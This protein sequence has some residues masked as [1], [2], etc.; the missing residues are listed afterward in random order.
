MEGLIFK[1]KRKRSKIK[2]LCV[3]NDSKIDKSVI[4]RFENLKVTLS[5][6]QINSLFSAINEGKEVDF[7]QKIALIKYVENIY[8]NFMQGV[9]FEYTFQEY[10][11]SEW[12]YIQTNEYFAYLIG[13]LI[14][15]YDN[16]YAYE[17]SSVQ[18]IIQ[19]LTEHEAYI[20]ISLQSIFFCMAG[21]Y[22]VKQAK[23]SQALNLF[24]KSN[25]TASNDLQKAFAMYHL[26]KHR[27]YSCDLLDAID[28]FIPAKKIYDYYFY[29]KS[30]LLVQI[31]IG[32]VYLKMGLYTK[33]EEIFL[34]CLNLNKQYIIESDIINTVCSLLF[35]SYLNDKNYNKIIESSKDMLERNINVVLCY[36][37]LAISYY[38][39]NDNENANKYILLAWKNKDYDEINFINKEMISAYRLV[40]NHKT[41]EKYEKKFLNIYQKALD[42]KDLHLQIYILETLINFAKKEDRTSKLIEYYSLLH[43]KYKERH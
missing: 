8:L 22:C 18:E 42:K 39:L 43:D 25:S 17:I 11:N 37:C 9:Q 4:S 41:F 40:I 36:V 16:D 35:Y 34:N 7:A 6:E 26:G 14:Y 19:I 1:I 29:I 30:S 28:L 3:E 38:Y 12:K 33:A 10:L 23:W 2:L 32:L 31:E 5:Q 27:S 24:M 21:L 20:P 15:G 13:L